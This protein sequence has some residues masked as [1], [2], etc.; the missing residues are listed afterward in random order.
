[1]RAVDDVKRHGG[2]PDGGQH[3][4]LRLATSA[5]GVARR[6]G[7]SGPTSASASAPTIAAATSCESLAQL[8]AADAVAQRAAN[9]SA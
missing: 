3:E 7:T 2:L 5:V 6:G 9:M 4:R 8:A 1:M